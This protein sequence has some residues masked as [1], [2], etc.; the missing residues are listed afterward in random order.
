M[1]PAGPKSPLPAR[2]PHGRRSRHRLAAV[3]GAALLAASVAACGS[4]S[5]SGGSGTSA[6]S[7]GTQAA[8]NSGGSGGGGL[9]KVNI[10]YTAPIAD[11]MLPEI[12]DAAGLFKK[13]G[14]DASI[15]FVQVSSALPALISG[16]LNYLVGGAPTSEV[17]S[18][19]GTTVQY[20]AQWEN[21]I[22]ADIVANKSAATA[23]DLDGKTMAISSTGALSDF[24]AQIANQRYGISIHEVPLG[25]LPNQL[26]AYS[27]GAVDSLSG[28]NPWQVA[29]LQKTVPGSHVVADFTKDPGY[30][31]VGLYGSADWLAKNRSTTV[32]V[33]RALIQGVAYY[34]SR[35][36]QSIAIIAKETDES[37]AEAK[38]A[39][40]TTEK[41]FTD[42]VVPTLADEQN[43]LKALEA[44]QPKAKGFDASKLFDAS[45]AKQ[46][47]G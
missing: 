16:Q 38:Q 45:Y 17:A 31:G 5:S 14:I 29:T 9:T 43:V 37:T 36:T 28:V 4:S 1:T 33:V 27:H 41:L 40:E 32:K 8:D 25:Q 39:Y 19:N 24:L 42:D 2:V 15:N 11:Q 34:K 13:N 44:S 30:P 35:P 46:A 21:V 12:T 23:K 26:T 7:T 20:V 18:L 22:D 3:A 47:Q 6:K 10:A